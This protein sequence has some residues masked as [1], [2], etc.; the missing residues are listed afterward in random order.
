MTELKCYKPQGYALEIENYYNVTVST[1][2]LVCVLVAKIVWLIM[3][4]SKLDKTLSR[5]DL[6]ERAC[7]GG[8]GQLCFV[9]PWD[10]VALILAIMTSHAS[11]PV[12]EVSMATK[13]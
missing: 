7:T 12:R 3:L 6:T 11:E 13:I 9:Q 8:R 2:S 5:G 10:C 1:G 4:N